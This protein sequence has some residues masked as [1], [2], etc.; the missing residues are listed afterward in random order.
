L[1][2]THESAYN[3]SKRFDDKSD[4]ASKKLPYRPRFMP[5]MADIAKRAGVSLSTVSHALSGKR[6]ISEET[7]Q[8]IFQAMAELDYQPHALARGL[9]T[10][11]SKIVALL[12]PFQLKGLLEAQFQFVTSAAEAASKLGYSLV[13]WTSPTEDM[14]VLRMTQQG[15]IDGLILM[16]I[17]LQDTRVQ[18]LRARDYPFSLIGRCQDNDG[19][20]FV[21]FDFENVIRDCVAYL[22]SLGHTEIGLI[23]HSPA[24]FEAGYGPVVRSYHSFNQAV[25]DWCLTGVVRLCEPTPENGYMATQTLLTDHPALTAIINMSDTTLSG[26]V[27]AIQ[28]AGHCIPDKFSVVALATP[29]NAELATLAL[30]TVDFPAAEMGRIGTEMLIKRLEGMRESEQLLL[31]PGLTVRQSTGLR[32]IDERR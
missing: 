22:A 5:T 12:L 9:A 23:A 26:M 32:A 17:M 4:L 13:L 3:A 30:T 7:K 11:R 2:R 16:E 27:Q 29:P 18:I 19:I 10:K 15:F 28:D 31:R 21:D 14:Q 25:Q 8:R 1:T 20:S 6:P 24:L